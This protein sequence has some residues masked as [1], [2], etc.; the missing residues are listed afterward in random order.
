MRHAK[1]IPLLAASTLLAV[2]PACGSDTTSKLI[3]VGDE[4]DATHLFEPGTDGRECNSSAACEDGDLCTENR[5]V[6]HTCRTFTLPTEEC[7]ETETLFSET[8][9]GTIADG[10]TFS[11]LNG[12]AGWHVLG[13]RNASPPDALYFGDPERMT[14]NVGAHVAG[15]VRLPAVDL[16]RDRE[17]VLTLRLYALIETNPQYDLFDV[18]ADVMQ[19]GQVASTTTLLE[20]RDLP[21]DSYLGFALVSASLK[22]LAGSTV[23]V[24]IRFDSVDDLNN[25]YEGV[26][27]D[28][29]QLLASC[30]LPAACAVDADCD[31]GDACTAEVCAEVGCLATNVCNL[32]DDNGTVEDDPCAK[33]D[34]PAD[35]CTSDADCEDGNPATV[36][37]CDGATCA[38]TLNPDM[39]VTAADCD[40]A[41][42]CTT[43]TCN[44]D[45]VCE[46][47]G[48]IGAGCCVPGSQRIADF[49]NETLQGIYVTDNF[50]TGIFWT[51]DLTRSTSGKFS[52][53]CG[54]PVT[55]TYT[56][57]RR[58]KSSATTRPLAIPSGGTTRLV[59]DL[60]KATRTAIN[61]DVF[62]VFVQRDG[63]LLP[64]WSS[65]LLT[66]GTTNGAWQHI[67]VPLT[68][69][70]GQEVQLRFVFDSVGVP[71]ESFEGT[72][73]DSLGLET[74][75]N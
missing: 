4:H 68:A 51:P 26:W 74:G 34:A 53:Y 21:V 67:V 22:D 69:Y 61:Y 23:V 28:D 29:I 72:Y 25:G 10:V 33:P 13:G 37:V 62:Q 17:T 56:Y 27:I 14:Y 38:V 59:F 54:D 7:C 46:F 9:D 5:C 35:C 50:E 15:E 43:E 71:P 12:D 11:Q 39:C 47:Q 30:P 57:D 1:L 32:P 2:L 45:G 65:K 75:C 3:Q 16:P 64:A 52:L 20:K 31:D 58:V 44:A 36:N 63:A 70:A 6:E 40:D 66:N 41:D 60:F 42:V 73:I 48:T 55:Q 24:R 8:F 49:D 18:V 19:D